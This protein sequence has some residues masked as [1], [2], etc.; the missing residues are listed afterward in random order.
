MENA[1]NAG[2]FLVVNDVI[3][4]PEFGTFSEPEGRAFTARIR[5]IETK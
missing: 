1:T 5:L 2:N 3:D 4:S